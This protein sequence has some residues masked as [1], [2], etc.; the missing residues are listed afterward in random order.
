MSERIK[1][2]ELPA[3]GVF[4]RHADLFLAAG[5]LGILF[6]LLVPLPAF[7][8][9]LAITIN[10]AA[11]LMVLIITLTV[12]EPLDFGTFPSLLLFTTLY[13]L[14]LNVASTRLILLDGSAGEVIQAF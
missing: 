12:R 4:G 3:N 5:M 10:L 14:A 1:L 11:A 9:D 13:R 6:I 7:L 2:P 8:L